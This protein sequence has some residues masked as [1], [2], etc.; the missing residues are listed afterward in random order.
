MYKRALPSHA[1]ALGTFFCVPQQWSRN[2]GYEHPDRG[3]DSFDRAKPD[4]TVPR[5]D[6][7]QYHARTKVDI[8]QH[9]VCVSCELGTDNALMGA[10]IVTTPMEDPC[11]PVVVGAVSSG[12]KIGF[13][14]NL[15]GFRDGSFVF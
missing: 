9:T 5:P 4:E 3:A 13:Q 12:N 1:R 10:I 14:G 6:V 2:I 11:E 8:I 7:G 15:I